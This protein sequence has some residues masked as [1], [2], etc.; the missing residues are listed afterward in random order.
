MQTLRQI[1]LFLIDTAQTFAIAVAMFLVVYFLIARPFQVSGDSMFPTYK[2]HEYIFTNLITP[3]FGTLKY[4]DVIVFLAPPSSNE[5]GKD[6]I[7]R[8]IGVPGDR[9]MLENGRVIKNGSL[10]E[11]SDYLRSDVKTFGGSFLSENREVIVPTGYYFVLGDNRTFSSD[12][13]EWG[14]LAKKSIIGKSFFVY[15]P[16]DQIRLTNN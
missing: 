2:D 6:F 11:E 14:F 12:S 9:I 7:K 1:W 3:R 15:W 10:L 4:G 16:L 8:V 13:R 5:E